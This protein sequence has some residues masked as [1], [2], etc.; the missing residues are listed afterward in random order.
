MAFKEVFSNEA[1]HDIDKIVSDAS[2]TELAIQF[3]DALE[4]LLLLIK[5]YPKAFQIKHEQVR[6]A[7]FPK[8][9]F[10]LAYM[11]VQPDIIYIIAVIHQRQEAWKDR[12]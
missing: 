6:I 11:I 4:A 3:F 12:I 7:V 1:N 10:K 8:L 5:T 9:P 2:S